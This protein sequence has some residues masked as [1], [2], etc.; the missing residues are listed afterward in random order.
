MKLTTNSKLFLQYLQ[1]AIL[2]VPTRT[3]MP[4]IE[5]FHFTLEDSRL[6]I[7]S[8]DLDVYI[9]QWFNVHSESDGWEGL[10]PAKKLLDQV[11]LLG[12]TSLILNALDGNVHLRAGNYRSKHSYTDANEFPDA[13]YETLENVITINGGYLARAIDTV[14]FACNPSHPMPAMT[15]INIH[16]TKDSLNVVATD[17]KQLALV[18]NNTIK[19][20]EEVSLVIPSKGAT[21]LQKFLEDSDFNL[22]YSNKGIRLIGDGFQ[23]DSRILNVNYPPYQQM[24]SIAPDK[25]V[26]INKSALLFALKRAGLFA[27]DVKSPN[28]TLTFENN[29]LQVSSTADFGSSDD[30]IECD[31]TLD[32]FEIH[33]DP[34]KLYSCV[35]HIQHETVALSFSQPNKLMLIEPMEQ[36]EDITVTMMVAPLLKRN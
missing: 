34:I 5:N 17:G 3:V 7:T 10:I 22:R 28:I 36:P 31:Y 24:L 32:K 14:L 18:S 6:T 27:S 9:R 8:T 1:K 15:G 12:D 11:K 19:S 4:S 13:P 21:A 23:F 20:E 16:F 35:N 30:L 29:G 33:L 25:R 2:A 26:N